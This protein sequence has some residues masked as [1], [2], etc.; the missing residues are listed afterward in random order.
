MR[1]AE[2]RTQHIIPACGLL[3]RSRRAG[4]GRG[5]SPEPELL[6]TMGHGE[7]APRCSARGEGVRWPAACSS[8]AGGMEL[9]GGLELVGAKVATGWQLRPAGLHLGLY[10]C[11]WV[12]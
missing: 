1:Q 10:F 5:G 4:V 6:C 12:P 2:H 9:A 3:L 8:A 7:G 11:Q